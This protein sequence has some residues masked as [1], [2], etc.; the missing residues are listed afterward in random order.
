MFWYEFL[1]IGV[2]YLVYFSVL[3]ACL[4]LNLLLPPVHHVYHIKLLTNERL[5]EKY[6]LTDSWQLFCYEHPYQPFHSQDGP[7]HNFL[8]VR[9]HHMA[10]ES[11]LVSEGMG[12]QGSKG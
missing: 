1:R 2:L 9:F 7:E 3:F 10:D 6:R 12:L 4:H 11:G 5:R 8:R